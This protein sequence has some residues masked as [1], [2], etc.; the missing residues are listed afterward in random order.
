ME[1]MFHVVYVPLME[2]TFHIWD[3]FRDST[4]W[5]HQYRTLCLWQID[6]GLRN[7]HVDIRRRSESDRRWRSNS[8]IFTSHSILF[9][10]IR[11]GTCCR[12]QYKALV[13][14]KKSQFHIIHAGAESQIDVGAQSRFVWRLT[15]FYLSALKVVLFDVSQHF[16][17]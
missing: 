13:R 1:R 4:C 15:A 8:F 5:R 11:D 2:R 16:I 7:K 3:V 6:V 9:C 14:H 17:L 10:N 12:H